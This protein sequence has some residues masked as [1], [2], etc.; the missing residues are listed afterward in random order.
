[1]DFIVRKDPFL[2]KNIL[3]SEGKSWDYFLHET[4]HKRGKRL[5]KAI[6]NE[7]RA[8]GAFHKKGFGDG[9][10]LSESLV[11][12]DPF[13]KRKDPGP[14]RGSAIELGG[15]IQ[16]VIRLDAAVNVVI[17]AVLAGAELDRARELI[18]T[19]IG[20]TGMAHRAGATAARP[21]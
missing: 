11:C 21:A 12:L 19:P 13:L 20:Q 7:D 2:Y 8:K 10:S 6:G 9:V 15:V 4:A 5:K 14:Q 1:M 17:R 3:V 18:K 16:H